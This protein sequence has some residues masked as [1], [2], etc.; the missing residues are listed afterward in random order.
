MVS[1]GVLFAITDETVG[2]LLAASSDARA[3]YFLDRLRSR[4]VVLRQNS[5]TRRRLTFR[6]TRVDARRPMA[7]LVLLL[8]GVVRAL[9]RPRSDLLLENLALRQQL[10]VLVHSGRR[11]R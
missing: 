10:A 1:R 5:F 7:R 6:G 11:D 3:G 4:A 2:A 8:L 9:M